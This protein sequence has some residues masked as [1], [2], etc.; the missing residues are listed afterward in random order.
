MNPAHQTA[1]HIEGGEELLFLK[2]L[3]FTR[4]QSSGEW[5]DDVERSDAL[6]LVAFIRALPPSFVGQDLTVSRDLGQAVGGPE[7]A[8]DT[9]RLDWLELR[10]VEVRNPLVYGSR[11]M[12]FATPDDSFEGEE[13]LSEIRAQIDAAMKAEAASPSAPNDRTRETPKNDPQEEQSDAGEVA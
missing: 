8:T 7:D 6:K 12:F 2:C 9:R 10:D 3:E 1:S 4:E 11:H 13:G 5:G